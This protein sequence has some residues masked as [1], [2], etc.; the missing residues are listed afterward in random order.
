M[1]PP[2]P[3]T[4]QK[5]LRTLTPILEVRIPIAQ[6]IWGKILHSRM[7]QDLVLGFLRNLRQTSQA[8][9]QVQRPLG[10]HKAKVLEHQLLEEAHSGGAFAHEPPRC[11]F[12]MRRKENIPM[13][14]MKEK[15]MKLWKPERWYIYIYTYIY[16]Y[17]Y[18]YICPK[19]FVE[20]FLVLPLNRTTCYVAIRLVLRLRFITCV[21]TS[22]FDAKYAKSPPSQRWSQSL[23]HGPCRLLNGPTWSTQLKSLKTWGFRCFGDFIHFQIFR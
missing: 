18:I 11:I 6:A 17:I 1:L 20:D 19:L 15:D 22:K 10:C 23:A 7:P 21:L 13:N 16:T 9:A 12:G 14:H 8:W 2:P 3:A 4:N 5:N